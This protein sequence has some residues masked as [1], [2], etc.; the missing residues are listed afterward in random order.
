VLP[1]PASPTLIFEYFQKVCALPSNVV[2]RPSAVRRSAACFAGEA[3]ENPEAG[4]LSAG[5]V[6]LP[7]SLPQPLVE[8]VWKL[9]FQFSDK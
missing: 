9:G 1:H 3:H 7:A 6:L 8:E 2:V 5:V 4:F